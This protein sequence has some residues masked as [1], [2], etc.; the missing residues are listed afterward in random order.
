MLKH[1]LNFTKWHSGNFPNQSQA[2]A[3]PSNVH[4]KVLDTLSKKGQETEAKVFDTPSNTGTIQVFYFNKFP[5]PTKVQAKVLDATSDDPR[6]PSDFL[7]VMHEIAEMTFD[8]SDFIEVV[9]VLD[10]HL[11]DEPVSRWHVSKSL[12]VIE[13]ALNHGS[14]TFVAYY[15]DNINTIKA[16]KRFPY[17]D[18]YGA[19]IGSTVR[20][21]ATAI[22]ALILDEARLWSNNKY[23]S[24]KPSLPIQSDEKYDRRCMG[25]DGANELYTGSRM[26]SDPSASIYPLPPLPVYRVDRRLEKRNSVEILQESWR[27]HSESQSK[28]HSASSSTLRIPLKKHRVHGLDKKLE[29]RLVDSKDNKFV[30]DVGQS[31]IPQGRG[32][33]TYTQYAIEHDKGPP[34]LD[35]SHKLEPAIKLA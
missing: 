5:A 13:Y 19:D 3:F 22:V 14:D 32:F 23:N 4:A 11:K 18:S 20:E 17:Y 1:A 24:D 6:T 15:C 28:D 34:P 12:A 25:F 10:S 8:P 31:S 2:K 9:G 29:F 7:I 33:E 16:L 30:Q 35:R 27:H 26:E 21:M